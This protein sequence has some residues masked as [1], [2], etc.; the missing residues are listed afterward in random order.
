VAF[1]NGTRQ[2]T[3]TEEPT[4]PVLGVD[5]TALIDATAKALDFRG[6]YSVPAT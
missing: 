6:M 5:Y 2:P 3:L 1:L 4:S